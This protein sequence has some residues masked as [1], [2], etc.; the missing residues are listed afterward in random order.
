MDGREDVS[1]LISF[2]EI[3][4]GVISLVFDRSGGEDEAE[5]QRFNAREIRNLSGDGWR[6]EGKGGRG[7]EE[8][9]GGKGEFLRWIPLLCWDFCNVARNRG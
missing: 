8:G 7:K 3:P 4:N 9:E 6:G 2:D 5:G 1:V